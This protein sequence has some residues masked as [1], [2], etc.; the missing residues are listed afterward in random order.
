MSTTLSPASIASIGAWLVSNDT[1]R[2]SKTMACIALGA[3][4]KLRTDAPYD[5]SDFGRCLRLVEVVPELR[6]CFGQIAEIEPRFAGILENWD[7]LEAIF[8][9]D[10]PT[11]TSS[12]LYDRIKKLRGDR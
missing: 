12:E 1:G 11:G 5:P 9:R 2:S 3:T 7:A 10:L 4:G 6:T 8:R